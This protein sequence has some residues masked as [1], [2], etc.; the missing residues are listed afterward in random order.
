MDG[1]PLTRLVTD[2]SPITVAPVV[3]G[4]TLVVVTRNGGIFGFHP[5]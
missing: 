2:G 3:V 5:E 4:K 1:T